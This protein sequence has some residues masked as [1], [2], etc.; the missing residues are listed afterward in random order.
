MSVKLKKRNKSKRRLN[1]PFDAAILNRATKIASEYQIVIRAEDGEYYGR[2]LE[3]PGT[4]DDGRTPD[5]CVEKT[6]EA[7]IAT[8]AYMLEKGEVPPA[9]A[10]QVERKVQINVRMTADEKQIIEEAA[11]ERGFAGIS[12]YIRASALAGTK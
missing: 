1:R 6:R 2:G 12:E 9:P 4:M 7:M 3:L 8:V 10:A 11:R 5:E